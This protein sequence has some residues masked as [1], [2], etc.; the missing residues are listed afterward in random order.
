[1]T[2]A[3]GI[4]FLIMQ[5]TSLVLFI[6]VLVKLF[7]NEG[8]LK[9]ILGFFCGIY[10][11]IWG[12][13]KHK[14]LALT[15]VMALWSFLFVASI[16][17]Q[18]FLATSGALELMNYA[19]NLQGNVHLKKAKHN[20]SQKSL[21]AVMKKRVKQ[22]KVNATNKTAVKKVADRSM[23]W[24]QKAMA[25][26]QNGK[27]KNPQKAIE[28]WG[29]AIKHK[30]NTAKAYNNRGLAYHDLKQYEL[31]IKDYSQA[32]QLDSSYVAAYN[33]RG[34]SYYEMAN[35]QE[36]L[37]DFNQS[38]QLKPDYSKAHLNRGLAFYQMDKN[39]QACTEFQKACDLGECDG[40]KWALKNEMC[41]SI[42]L[43][44]ERQDS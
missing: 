31:A 36:A 12:W 44:A 11:F 28:L 19:N 16:V 8:A 25:L 3:L 37:K 18:G 42:P 1:M 4:A 10:T 27:Y 6:M 30:Q 9:G 20:S 34:N 33:N 5:I 7:K 24:S 40:L 2:I 17:M 15:K 22:R 41:T 21:K 35:Y 23:D 13:L 14:E 32:I 29:Q 38:L 39:I 43:T 26:W